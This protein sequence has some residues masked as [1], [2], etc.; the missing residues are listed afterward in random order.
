MSWTI[1]RRTKLRVLGDPRVYKGAIRA[2]QIG[3]PG[4]LTLKLEG[5]K[6]H[7]TLTLWTVGLGLLASPVAGQQPTQAEI[8]QYI[9]LVR[10]D[11]RQGRAELVGQ[12]MQLSAG[13]AAQFWP[14]YEQY[15]RAF[16]T[17]GDTVLQIVNDY[18]AAFESMTDEAAS[19]LAGRQLDLLDERQAL[20]REYHGK[21]E[22]ALG[23]AVAA[24]FVQVEHRIET[25][26]DLQ[27]AADIPLLE[28]P[29]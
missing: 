8:D 22:A 11:V 3:N 2:R 26:L 14:L 29:R 27:L 1:V 24:R 17:L 18:A 19:Q 12:A 23:G 5:S 21:F 6:S 4:V 16:T 15:E 25:L 7:E 20:R 9:E 13:Q 28:P 10:M